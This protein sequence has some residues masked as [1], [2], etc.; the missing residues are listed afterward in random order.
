MRK[1]DFLSKFLLWL[2]DKDKDEFKKCT[3]TPL[4]EGTTCLSTNAV[5]IYA[6]RFQRHKEEFFGQFVATLREELGALPTSTLK[7]RGR[8]NEI[9]GREI[10][11]TDDADDTRAALIDLIVAAETSD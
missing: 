2:H 10:D 4:R 7:G 9:T 3:A 1:C 6:E 8:W 5:A 11:K